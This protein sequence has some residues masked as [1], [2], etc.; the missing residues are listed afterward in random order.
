[1]AG[2]DW[3]SGFFSRFP[4]LSIRAPE[5]TSLARAVGFNKPK[6]DQFFPVYKQLLK[7]ESQ[8]FTPE[9]NMEYG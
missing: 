3:L 2:K 9:P 1:M 4:D 8:E 6:V 5:A 7:L